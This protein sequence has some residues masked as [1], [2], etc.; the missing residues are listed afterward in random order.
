MQ[1]FR[2][3]I[4][5]LSSAAIILLGCNPIST[6][7]TERDPQKAARE[8]FELYKKL[9]LSSDP[10][11]ID[12]YAYGAEING[13]GKSYTRQEY[14]KFIAE[15]YKAYSEINGKTRFSEPTFSAVKNDSVD[16]QFI[17]GMERQLDSH[18]YM[19]V[20]W[21]LKKSGS[22]AWEI[23]SEKVVFGKEKP[24]LPL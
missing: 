10:R 8:V 1:Q 16:V 5:C 4:F 12:L 2:R 24:W 11:I 15:T 19:T 21:T 23:S 3:T 17:V 9:D 18:V 14:G 7:V 22:G 13:L 6:R 20:N